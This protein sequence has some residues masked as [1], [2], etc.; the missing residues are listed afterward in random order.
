MVSSHPIRHSKS[1]LVSDQG[2]FPR[3]FGGNSGTVSTE[4]WSPLWPWVHLGYSAC[5]QPAELKS[6]NTFTRTHKGCTQA[7]ELHYYSFFFLSLVPTGRNLFQNQTSLIYFL[8]ALCPSGRGK[9]CSRVSAEQIAAAVL[10]TLTISHTYSSPLPPSI[11]KFPPFSPP[12]WCLK[13]FLS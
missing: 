8:E 4:D 7:A 3:H 10:V 9:L 6:P 2:G 13:L 5:E 11:L 1:K 12:F